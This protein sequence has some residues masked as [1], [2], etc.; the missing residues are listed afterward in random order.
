VSRCLSNA[1]YP[2]ISR[3]TTAWPDG[4][5]IVVGDGPDIALSQCDERCGSAGGR[6]EL[7]LDTVRRIDLDDG[8]EIASP[9]PVIGEVTI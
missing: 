6:H 7:D 4:H 1:I 2:S 9:K 5:Q 8:A 3:R